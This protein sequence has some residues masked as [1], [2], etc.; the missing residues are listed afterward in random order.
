MNVLEKTTILEHKY[1]LIK[2]D[3]ARLAVASWD[4]SIV[5][6]SEYTSELML[7]KCLTMLLKCLH[8]KSALQ[9]YQS[10]L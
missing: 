3:L 1:V 6:I 10:A 8:L 9:C 4:Q 5:Y 2:T 7:P